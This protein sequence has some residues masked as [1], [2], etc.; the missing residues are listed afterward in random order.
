M[1]ETEILN[2]IFIIDSNDNSKFI[3]N[4]YDLKLADVIVQK[5]Y[6]KLQEL[7]IEH[8]NYENTLSNNIILDQKT[9]KYLKYLRNGFTPEDDFKSYMKQYLIT[10]NKNINFSG[11]ISPYKIIESR[12][13]FLDFIF[14]KNV[15]NYFTNPPYDKKFPLN[16][17]SNIH[18]VNIIKNSI[19]N[20]YIY[21]GLI[22]S[23]EGLYVYH[24]YPEFLKKIINKDIPNIDEYFINLK[25]LLGLSVEIKTTNIKSF[26]KKRKLLQYHKSVITIEKFME[27]LRNMGIYIN[28]Y[29]YDEEQ[30]NIKINIE[31][32]E[33]GK[34]LIG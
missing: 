32:Y 26:N 2:D 17:P 3:S 4:K 31:N 33:Y 21:I 6:L 10:K 15:I 18:I 5:W 16:P 28:L 27:S 13:K 29:S 12:Y 8:E 24:L 9:I 7:D 11:Y 19:E 1:N 25:N 22:A 14:R 30:I 23:F 34:Y 20:N